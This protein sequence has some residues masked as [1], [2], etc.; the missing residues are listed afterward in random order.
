VYDDPFGNAV[1]TQLV[2]TATASW[3]D[4]PALTPCDLPTDD[5]GIYCGGAVVHL[6]LADP[7]VPNELVVSYSVGTTTSGPPTT[8]VPDRYWPRLVWVH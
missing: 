6:E 3:T 7:T 2:S 8:N 4:G 5:L 1:L